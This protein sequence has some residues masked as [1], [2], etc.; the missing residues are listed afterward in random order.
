MAKTPKTPAVRLPRVSP[1]R[2][3]TY[4]ACPRQYYFGYVRKMPRRARSYFS[5]GTSLHST[6]QGFHQQGGV[7]TQ[8][9]ADL[10][11]GLETSWV[12]AGYKNRE[13]Q[14]ARFDL[15]QQL[16]S[17]YY[18]VE[19]R[20][21]S[22]T[23]FMEKMLSVPQEG[24]VLTGRIDRIDRRPD[25]VLEVVDYKSGSYLPALSELEEDLAIAVYQLLVSKAMDSEPV[26]GTI[27]NL[28]A[29]ESVSLS[30]DG[31]A[32]QEVQS[33]V[34]NLFQIISTDSEYLPRPGSQCRYCDFARYCPEAAEWS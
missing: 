28:R 18:E 21:E 29:N 23:L 11:K 17:A 2:L 20:R 13:E 4:E 25:G 14:A 32:L 16:L 9:P 8:Q 27:Y 1:T 6:L 12:D 10:L 7:Q 26:V 31:Q 34:G 3:N 5:F 19:A 33:R 30:R 15:G 22:E 24:F